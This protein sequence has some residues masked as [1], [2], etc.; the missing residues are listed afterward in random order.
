M[1]HFD[2]DQ[3]GKL[4]HRELKFCLRALGYDLQ[5]VEG[6]QVEPGFLAVLD[7]VDPN[8][9]RHV[10]LQEYMAFMIS[11]ETENVQSSLEVDQVFRALTSAEKPF[12]TSKPKAHGDCSVFVVCCQLCVHQHF[13]KKVFF[14]KTTGQYSQE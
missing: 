13:L 2:K 5:V 8:R 1:R 4:D 3:S 12:I 10:S 9:D 6:G 14:F 11:R 7:M